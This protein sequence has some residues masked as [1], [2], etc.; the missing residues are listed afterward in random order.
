MNSIYNKRTVIFFLVL[1]CI[2]FTLIQ[3]SPLGLYGLHRITGGP[4]ILDLSFPWYSADDAYEVFTALGPEGR[5]FNLTKIL[6]LDIFFPLSYGFFFCTLTGIMYKT[7]GCKK[8]IYTGL[9]LLGIFAA[10]LDLLENIC[11]F[12]MLKSYP[13]ISDAAARSS[14]IFT[15]LKFLFFGFSVILIIAG[16]SFLLWKRKESKR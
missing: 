3:F 5:V 11:I 9:S 15:Q 4:S 16:A 8:R 6:P 2:A 12:I 14:N 10:F 7:G 13:S 1:F